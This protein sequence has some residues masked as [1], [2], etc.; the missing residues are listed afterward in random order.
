MSRLDDLRVNDPMYMEYLRDG[1]VYNTSFIGYNLNGHYTSRSDV[2]V[3]TR[4][5][6]G[7]RDPTPYLAIYEEL[8]SITGLVELEYDID[9]TSRRLKDRSI[10]YAIGVIPQPASQL[11]YSLE[12]E[13][14]NKVLRK[15]R[16]QNVNYAQSLA[17]ASQTLRMLD[18]ASHNQIARNGMQ[19]I[20]N[21]ISQLG[22][23]Y[24]FAKRGQWSRAAGAL[25]IPPRKFVKGAK[26]VSGRWLELRYGWLPLLSDI[27]G[28]FEDITTKFRDLNPR[29][30][31]KAV[32]KQGLPKNFSWFDSAWSYWGVSPQLEQSGF[33]LCKIR[34]DYE[35]DDEYLRNLSRIG[36][37]DPLEIAWELTPFSFVIDWAFP[38][39]NFLS[40]LNSATGLRF[41]A[42]TKT[43]YI[44]CT[45]TAN[46]SSA[47]SP[48]GRSVSGNAQSIRKLRY[49]SRVEYSS[50][51]IALPY[52][53]NPISTVHILDSLALLLQKLK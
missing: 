3:R 41:K 13:T 52:L 49:M 11:P 2:T 20:V 51:P 15:V 35:F 4:D 34:L 47:P 12:Q 18:N 19:H 33:Q 43:F 29:F 26:D 38:I 31:C 16:N 50:T 9:K 25:K 24:T 48:V 6:S 27:K 53:R 36:L 42:G 8:N 39:S 32:V 10:L 1:S 46:F 7:W 37:S 44:D 40:G 23:A 28:T 21:R 5:P 22:T 45:R 14:V 17:E 30:S